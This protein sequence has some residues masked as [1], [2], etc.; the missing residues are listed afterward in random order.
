M[1]FEYPNWE[2]DGKPST[3]IGH[4]MLCHARDERFELLDYDF[5]DDTSM[6]ML[7]RCQGTPAPISKP[8]FNLIYYSFFF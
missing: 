8:A 3:A 2:L 6:V 7:L 5:F 4:V 1:K